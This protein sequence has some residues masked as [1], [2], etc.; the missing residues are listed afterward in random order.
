M[1]IYCGALGLLADRDMMSLINYNARALTRCIKGRVE[2]LSNSPSNKLLGEKLFCDQR[3][4]LASFKPVPF[5]GWSNW[6]Q[7]PFNNRS[8][9]W[10]LNW[11]SFLPYLMA[12]HK[13]YGDDAALNMA[14]AAI[15]S[16]LGT[17]LETDTSYPFEF[18]WHDHATA[19]RAEQLCLFVYYCRAHAPIW[20]ESQITFLDYME[21]ALRVHGEWLAKDGFYSEHTNH[22]LEQ[23]RVLL[24][25]G[26]VFDSTWARE[27]QVIALRR[28]NSELSFAFTE[29][30]VHVENSPA[31]HIFVFKVF[32]GIIK[33]YPTEVLGD[34]G[35]RFA[36]FSTK[37]LGFIT[38][39]LR[40][41]GTL[42]PI[43]DTEQ[44][45]TSDS[46]RQVFGHTLAYQHFLYA[47]TQG[48]QG[49]PPC[50][51]NKIYPK[52]GY[53][54][55]RDSWPAHPHYD[56]AF[57]LVA[58]VG[59]S[60]RYHH[61]Q[62]EGHIS[63]YAGG[64][65]WLIDSG[66]YNYINE[67]PVRK[68]MRGRAGHNVPLISHA[69][70]AK[71]FGHRLGAWK[72]TQHSETTPNPSLMMQLAVMPPV[73]HERKIDFDAQKQQLAVQDTVSEN[74]EQQR[75]I[76]LQWHFPKDK[77]I[78]IADGQV[79][80]SSISGS[81]L[82]ISFSGAIPD[83]LVVLKGRKGDQVRSCIS[84]EMNKLESSQ[85]LQVVFRERVGLQVT[86]NFQFALARSRLAP[87]PEPS[88][89]TVQSLAM[90][91]AGWQLL[92]G[93]AHSV[94][95]GNLPASLELAKA[96]RA[97]ALGHVSLLVDGSQVCKTA[98]AQFETHCLSAWLDC[99]PIHAERATSPFSVDKA[100][101]QGLEGI[102]LLLVTDLDL[103]ENSLER[104][105][106]AILPPL[107]KRMSKTGQVWVSNDLSAPLKSLCETW[108][109]RRGLV[110]VFFTDD[111]GAE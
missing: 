34:L 96:H 79:L 46:Y 7:N 6:E 11:L 9:Q 66:L 52:S 33:E 57:H 92:E 88:P 43:G 38:Y 21:R 81:Q 62:D 40:P 106:I 16:W 71:D 76:T 28:I 1:K 90:L 87:I 29:E 84:Y 27:W 75:N 31:Y 105:L 44:L 14:R 20:A 25:L 51:F 67:D 101:M 8:W 111:L 36:E 48:K 19:L 42:P 63:L 60:S 100:V 5:V 53:A 30:G 73:V 15:E 54:I 102:G 58:K 74:D 32:I 23:A 37:A 80:V 12:Y 56:K 85:L 93:G 39:I 91:L 97:L 83:N 94:V 35:T 78:T 13:A 26:T 95:L 3:L 89:S 77:T 110:V 17:Y 10:R 109:R 22:G 104:V 68:Y 69:N 98:Q 64:E 50:A 4:E 45:P 55:F 41:D 108:A 65:D 82:Q 24:L 47:Q 86:T 103:P 99:R 107:L 18:I 49:V 59:C 2:Q 72:V 70:Y 61:Q